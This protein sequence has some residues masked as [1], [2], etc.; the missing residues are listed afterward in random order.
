MVDFTLSARPVFF[1]FTIMIAISF[2]AYS[3]AFSQSPDVVA[4]NKFTQNPVGLYSGAP[5]ISLPLGSVDS[6]GL[7]VNVGI[8]YHPGG[9][10]VEEFGSSTGLGWS[11]GAG[12]M[13][14]RT[15]EGID[16][17]G[18]GGYLEA[19]IP[20]LQ[21]IDKDCMGT[22][23]DLY[24]GMQNILENTKDSSPDLFY[25]SFPGGNGK[26][27]FDANGDPVVLDQFG[28][29]IQSP[30][31]ADPGGQWVITTLDGTRYI[32]GGSGRV[33]RSGGVI[34][35]WYLAEITPLTGETAY[36]NYES[37]TFSYSLPALKTQYH[38]LEKET[39]SS[40]ESYSLEE[41]RNITVEALYPST[42][43]L[44]DSRI[45]FLT[46][47]RCDLPGARKIDKIRLFHNFGK[48]LKEYRL[49]YDCDSGKKRL[50]LLS[51]QELGMDGSVLRPTKFSYYNKDLMPG[52]T[53][54]AQDHWGYY[55]GAGNNDL[56]PTFNM[57]QSLYYDGANRDTHLEKVKYGSL[58]HVAHAS[59]GITDYEFESHRY[60][61]YTTGQTYQEVLKTPAICLGGF[62]ECLGNNNN[63]SQPFTLTRKTK[64]EISYALKRSE[65]LD[66]GNPA[67][68]LVYIRSAPGL[69]D[70]F[71]E[72]ITDFSERSGNT[73]ITLPAGD[74]LLGADL[75]GSANLLQ[76]GQKA[77][78]NLNYRALEPSGTAQFVEYGGGLRIKK[79]T[80][81]DGQGISPPVVKRFAYTH[82]A[83]G[84]PAGRL[85]SRPQYY[86]YTDELNM[87]R[88]GNGNITGTNNCTYLVMTSSSIVPLTT[89]ASGGYV[90]YDYVTGY[91]GEM[92]GPANGRI[93]YEYYNAADVPNGGITLCP[94]LPSNQY[95]IDALPYAPP[96]V[97]EAR[98]GYL[99]RKQVE[100][101]HSTSY[102]P[103]EEVVYHY[104]SIAQESVP[105]W[106][107]Y[108]SVDPTYIT[109]PERC[110][111][112]K[113]ARYDYTSSRIRL[114]STASTTFDGQGAGP[115][116]A[117]GTTTS[118][119]YYDQYPY[120][121]REVRREDGQGR[122]Y[123]QKL[124]RVTDPDFLDTGMNNM[125]GFIKSTNL[126]GTVID[127]QQW[128]LDGGVEK[129]LSSGV[130]V[131]ENV[132]G[133][134]V[135]K[136]RYST[137]LEDPVTGWT[138]YTGNSDPNPAY[139]EKTLAHIYN[140]ANAT[141]IE[142]ND[143]TGQSISW[144]Y[145]YSDVVPIA[146]ISNAHH[147][148][149]AYTS[150]EQDAPGNWEG[151]VPTMIVEN[152]GKTGRSSYTGSLGKCCL[153][154]GSYTVALWAK[155]AGQTINV[156]GT[157]RN[158][159]E[160]WGYYVWKGL[161]ASSV[162]IINSGARMDEV[163]LYPGHAIMQTYTLD[164]DIGITSA[165]GPNGQS[166][167]HEYDGLQRRKLTR[168]KDGH[169]VQRYSYRFK[170]LPGFIENDRVTAFQPAAFRFIGG[171][172]R[173]D[174]TF[175]WDFGDGSA[176]KDG[177]SVTHS[178]GQ[179]GNFMVTFSVSDASGIIDTYQK[180]TFVNG[181]LQGD[182][183]V[184]DYGNRNITVNAANNAANPL[185]TTYQ[186]HFGPLNS[187]RT[188]PVASYQYPRLGRQTITLTMDH[189]QYASVTRQI[190]HVLTGALSVS[191]IA[192]QNIT[193]KE[194]VTFYFD[195][196][197][198][199]TNPPDAD[200]VWNFGDG[201]QK[202]NSN[203]HRYEL[204]GNYTV[205][206]KATHAEYPDS[207]FETTLVTVI[208]GDPI[209]DEGTIAV[210]IDYQDQ[211]N[212]SDDIFT[213]T[214]D[215]ARYGQGPYTYHWESQSAGGSWVSQ[216]TT[217]LPQ[218]SFNFS[219]PTILRVRAR[220]QR[221]VYSNYVEQQ[222]LIEIPQ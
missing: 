69:I 91:E 76:N 75:E 92:T 215:P 220:D 136:Y 160:D 105:G 70:H 47:P 158:T 144:V 55:N 150:F 204:I 177:R 102:Y 61:P 33:E 119:T 172:E 162:S 184:T 208:Y 141:P 211:G 71:S 155:G 165:T 120:L 84:A 94:E 34:T 17:F 191:P 147:D 123:I 196:H 207:P 79:I 42:I 54:A 90:G 83:T 11:L 74:Y 143:K 213:M 59:G 58:S 7:S 99:K 182:I 167:Y 214:F 62:A 45:E 152:D 28:I 5:G 64:I 68:V 21:G 32:F 198:P 203:S 63:Y 25:F 183:Q 164:P 186:W 16:D 133:V 73:T 56:R 129:L 15:I 78:I 95:A 157:V 151:L 116:N 159:G 128:V 153:P 190:E 118:Y 169:V 195:S 4:T 82:P 100:R 14:S 93:V 22:S 81:R 53:S 67:R 179:L 39:G 139:Y 173:T 216:G 66:N 89:T 87:E 9:I 148:Q 98:K 163:R 171:E 222:L 97:T 10:R 219:E 41:E 156:N 104:T 131:F 24:P 137:T 18:T 146:E 38:L 35:A 57:S 48:L 132:N 180:E 60:K 110:K 149:V 125:I 218:G 3:K 65:P 77:A 212:A 36:F 161:Q 170:G 23:G 122:T 188:G 138:N 12:G 221:N 135:P 50:W 178:Y 130:S 51:V 199:P 43:L 126:L 85:M 124:R 31:N 166:V 140:S 96:T 8:S 112:V 145:G 197:P 193:V 194:N 80:I 209:L 174:L 6:R 103:I 88:D 206:V 189:P 114:V 181:S 113:I 185:G 127:E 108:G 202:A 44:N 117:F 2:F 19:G 176:A 111:Y 20:G 26:F 121:A 142:Q 210:T 72:E 52:V 1:H 13:I 201:T 187:D 200:Y 154:Q 217:S 205:N 134:V 168:D 49:E 30:V 37:V 86:Y 109:S 101:S 107:V 106:L 175:S 27:V 115:G 192:Q 29:K 46:S 40:C